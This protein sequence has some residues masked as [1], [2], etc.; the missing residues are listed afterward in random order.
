MPEITIHYSGQVVTRE[1]AISAGLEFIFLNRPYKRNH[2]AKR[3]ISG[4]CYQCKAEDRIKGKEKNI[5]YQRMYRK[6]EGYKPKEKS[7]HSKE[8]ARIRDRDKYRNNREFYKEKARLRR[9]EN[10]EAHIKRGRNYYY[11]RKEKYP[12]ANKERKD[13]ITFAQEI[14]K[15]L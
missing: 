4:S 9:I 11:K 15:L 2:I 10:H 1:E 7:I 13:P 5:L 8:K 3:Y 6:R 12:T 14:G